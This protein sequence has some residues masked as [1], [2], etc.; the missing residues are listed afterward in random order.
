[1]ST[2]TK[3]CLAEIHQTYLQNLLLMLLDI[4]CNPW[5]LYAKTVTSDLQELSLDDRSVRFS[6]G[7]HH[8]GDIIFREADFF[9][10]VVGC[11]VNNCCKILIYINENLIQKLIIVGY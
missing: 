1:M 11:T 3:V 10:G 7:L 2:V 8:H 6:S 9:V 4:L 5:T